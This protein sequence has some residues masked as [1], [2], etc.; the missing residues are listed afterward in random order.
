MSEGKDGEDKL[1]VDKVDLNPSSD[2]ANALDKKSVEI[3]SDSSEALGANQADAQI[4]AHRLA[5]QQQMKKLFMLVGSALVALLLVIVGYQLLNAPKNLDVE[6]NETP[7][8]ELSQ[9]QVDAYR[10]AFKKALTQYEVNIQPQLNNIDFVSYDPSTVGELKLLKETVLS[11]FANGAFS[12]SKANLD[13]LFADSQTLIDKWNADFEER[14][15]VAENLFKDLK[16]P[17]AQ[18][19]LNRAEALKP[20]EPKVIALQAR[21]DAYGE[22]A[23]LLNDLN[24]AKVERNLPKQIDLMSDIIALDPKRSGITKDLSAVKEEY[25]LG[26]LTSALERAEQAIA[27]NKFEEAEKYIAQ[28][29]SIKPSS[30]GAQILTQKIAQL[31]TSSSLAQI[32]TQIQNNVQNDNWTQVQS[33]SAQ[34]LKQHPKDTQLTQY[35][36]QATQVLQANQQIDNFLLRPQRLADANIKRA[37]QNTMQSSF[38][39]AMRSPALQ[40]K[41]AELGELLDSYSSPVDV[42]VQSDANTYIVVVGVGH[43]GQHE[44]KTISLT[45]GKYVLEGKRDGYRSKRV[46]FEVSANTPISVQLVCD[47]AL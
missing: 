36:Q 24:V 2:Q 29:K 33:L 27:N 45:P 25:S 6:E 3:H 18:L 8:V 46:N 7:V 37:A 21:I 28:A 11:A 1:L 34:A 42:T 16:I 47:E 35:Q 17:Q 15:D 43:V 40:S 32:K 12:E 14:L 9:A 26:Q 38:S 22:I 30:K 5:H 31:R 13:K 4:Q 10:E 44:S 23:L 20:G 19:S 41:I 39:A